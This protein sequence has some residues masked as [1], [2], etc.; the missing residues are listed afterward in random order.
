MRL[1]R[2]LL[3][4]VLVCLAAPLLSAATARE[5]TTVEVVQ[6]PVYIH[7]NA[8]S[9]RGL[10]RDNFEL[11]VN[12]KRQQ[13]DYFDVVDFAA[14]SEQQA[15]DPRQRRLYV[16]MFD[17]ANSSGVSALR[18]KRAAETY[19]AHAQASDYF[20]VALLNHHNGIDFI[21]PFTRDRATLRR[22]VAGFSASAPDD[23]LRLTVTSTERTALS[24]DDSR[25]IAGLRSDGASLAA[26]MA[27]EVGRSYAVDEMNALGD[28]A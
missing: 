9:V 5:K 15:R 27:I 3:P 23:P 11:R 7:T 26:E 20:A 17:L 16:L 12:G 14:V 22:A 21:V 25:E 19:L 4:A 10:T 28:L 8:G 1:S 18:A 24:H 2:V 13:I 6:V